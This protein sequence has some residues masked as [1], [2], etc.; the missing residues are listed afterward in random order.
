MAGYQPLA[1]APRAAR[2]RRAARAL[3]AA[4]LLA[5][6]LLA[7]RRALDGSLRAPLPSALEEILGIRPA[8]SD[9]VAELAQPFALASSLQLPPLRR[10][11]V[12]GFN[13]WNAFGCD[14]SEDLILTMAKAI[15][16]SGLQ[17]A[18]YTYICIDDCWQA[19]ERAPDGRLQAHPHRFP[20]NGFLSLAMTHMCRERMKE[21][22]ECFRRHTS[23]R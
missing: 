15:A 22:P 13:T 16:Q 12:M 19:E 4:A 23:A 10:T 17:E 2:R 9:K 21:S 14:I 8:G 7:A 18:G 1:D 3:A 11:P 6:A 20:R 5:A